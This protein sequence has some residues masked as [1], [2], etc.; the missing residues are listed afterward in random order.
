M[1]ELADRIAEAEERRVQF[2]KSLEKVRNKLTA[3]QLTAEAMALL[4]EGLSVPGRVRSAA[5]RNPFFTSAILACA[6]YVIGGA[7]KNSAS[8]RPSPLACKTRT[9]NGAHHIAKESYD[10]KQYDGKRRR[11]GLTGYRKIKGRPHAGKE[12][13]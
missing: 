8:S 13:S 7:F 12:E 6:A 11:R 2:L 1:D 9:D 10:E 5:K 4:G 3:P